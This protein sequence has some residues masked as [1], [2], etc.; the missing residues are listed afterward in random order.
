MAD[1]KAKGGTQCHV[2]I[3]YGN[4]C[5][6]MVVGNSRMNVKGA[7]SSKGAEDMAMAQCNSNDTG[8]RLYY[9]A[10]SQPKLQ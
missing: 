4:G 8:C 5:V 3:S 1:C 6:A 7:A 2:E 9:V 10:C